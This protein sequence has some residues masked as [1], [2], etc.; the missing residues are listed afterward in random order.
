MKTK[1]KMGMMLPQGQYFWQ[2]PKARRSKDLNI[3]RAFGGSAVVLT[4]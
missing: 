1:A 4:P 2:T 3:P